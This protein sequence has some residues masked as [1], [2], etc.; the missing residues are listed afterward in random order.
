MHTA[1]VIQATNAR[2]SGQVSRTMA[3]HCCNSMVLDPMTTRPSLRVPQR[4]T[5]SVP[6]DNQRDWPARRRLGSAHARAV[7]S[8]T[9]LRQ[10]S[11]D[12]T[13]ASPIP[14]GGVGPHCTRIG[15]RNRPT[16]RWPNVKAPKG[17]P[18]GT[19]AGWPPAGS[20]DAPLTP[21]SLTSLFG[22]DAWARPGNALALLLVRLLLDG[23]LGLGYKLTAFP[24]GGS[25]ARHRCPAPDY[26]K[27]TRLGHG[28][29]GARSANWCLDSRAMVAAPGSQEGPDMM[30]RAAAGTR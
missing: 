2:T 6:S 10:W 18:Y 17:T 29:P 13:A 8:K 7:C 5:L 11:Q 16:Y 28:L 21:R 26:G 4:I 3:L 14:S 19:V 12:L 22:T 30:L 9:L 1:C 24:P 27:T 25:T 20:V 23:L 15:V